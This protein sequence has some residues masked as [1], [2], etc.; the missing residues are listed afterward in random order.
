MLRSHFSRFGVF[1]GAA[2]LSS[3]CAIPNTIDTL[4]DLCPPPEF[5]RPAW[6]RV[7]AGTGAWIGGIFG[8]VASI[9]LLPITYPMSLLA[10]DGLGE[11][12]SSEF[13]LFPALGGAAVG[14]CLLGTPPDV[15]DYLFRRVW[16]GTEDPV[17]QYDFVPLPGP[18]I[19]KD[20]PP[21]AEGHPDGSR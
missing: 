16:V 6:V 3:A 9:V 17:M 12:A 7:C 20:L 13:M 5:G 14:H 2:L 8:G 4:D 10:D 15:L 1:A 19:P 18:A 11:H 21:P